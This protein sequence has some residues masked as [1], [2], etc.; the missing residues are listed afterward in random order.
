M[1][2]ML[3]IKRHYIVSAALLNLCWVSWFDYQQFPWGVVMSCRLLSDSWHSPSLILSVTRDARE[4]YFCWFRT[5]TRRR[6]TSVELWILLFIWNITIFLGVAWAGILINLAGHT[7]VVPHGRT[8]IVGSIIPFRPIFCQG[9]MF[10]FGRILTAGRFIVK[11]SLAIYF[12]SRKRLSLE[13][14]ICPTIQGDWHF[15]ICLHRY[16]A[17]THKTEC[18]W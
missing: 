5:F 16:K 11:D 8:P 1:T 2:E 15:L 3:I 7:D 9:G 6:F 12:L 14:N 4:L 18:F 13:S 17:S 10:W